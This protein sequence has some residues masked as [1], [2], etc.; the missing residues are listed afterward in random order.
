MKVVE[1][2]GKRTLNTIPYPLFAGRE[3]PWSSHI[4]RSPALLP[5]LAASL[6]CCNVTEATI[7]ILY[8]ILILYS[9]EGREKL[10]D[11][12]DLPLNKNVSKIGNL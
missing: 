3:L 9:T 7:L 1:A 12:F 6:L 2:M 11:K 10:S 8:C 4:P 5:C